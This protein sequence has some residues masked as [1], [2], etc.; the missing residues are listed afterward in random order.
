MGHAVFAKDHK[1][2]CACI[3]VD[4]LSILD[5]AVRQKYAD[6]LLDWNLNAIVVSHNQFVILASEKTNASWFCQRMCH[7]IFTTLQ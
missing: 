1:S 6:N 5:Y 7:M 3:N 4:L 2:V